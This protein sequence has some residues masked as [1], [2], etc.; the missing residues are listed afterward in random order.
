MKK[1]CLLLSFAM[2]LTVLSACKPKEEQS[3]DNDKTVSKEEN[4][5]L[6]GNE[7]G[8][9]WISDETP[10]PF[11]S[12]EDETPKLELPE[13]LVT[14]AVNY[15]CGI[16]S[17]YDWASDYKNHFVIPKLNF[18]TKNSKAFNEKIYKE[19]SS[20]YEYFKNYTE[21]GGVGDSDKNDRIYYIG[22][23][24]KIYNNI[25]G[26]SVYEGSGLIASDAGGNTNE[27][28]Y[29]YDCNNDK[30]L[31]FEEYLGA[32]GYTKAEAQK[33]LSTMKAEWDEHKVLK[34]DSVLEKC[35]IDSES[36]VV[37][38]SNINSYAWDGI[39][40]LPDDKDFIWSYEVGPIVKEE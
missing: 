36:T 35:L 31:T 10:A 20:T 25:V 32:F 22:Y 30:E 2:L 9:D 3:A 14:D 13:N 21:K 19:F 5:D 23:T 18:E 40:F 17:D 33:K 16:I 24:C 11:A 38:F 7:G 1:L 4:V 37:Y 29:Y 12:K 8:F 15:E 28:V 6:S 27:K 39:D 34:A 26:L